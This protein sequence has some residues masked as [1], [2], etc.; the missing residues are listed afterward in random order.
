MQSVLGAAGAGTGKTPWVYNVSFAKP[1]GAGSAQQ[2][3]VSKSDLRN[4]RITGTSS[5]CRAL[6]GWARY[7]CRA[8]AGT[9]VLKQGTHT[10]TTLCNQGVYYVRLVLQHGVKHSPA[11]EDSSS[12]RVQPQSS[13]RSGNGA[14]PTKRMTALVETARSFYRSPRQS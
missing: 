7:S 1:D 13:M 3:N 12:P 8:Q 5:G 10:L 4:R 14:S 11:C 6:V 9:C 2:A